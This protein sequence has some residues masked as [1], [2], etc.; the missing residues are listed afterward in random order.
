MN[1]IPAKPGFL[2]VFSPKVA[3]SPLVL[4]VPHAGRIYP[5]SLLAQS[6]LGKDALSALEDRYVDR[7]VMPLA[8]RGFALIVAGAARALIDINRSE[9]EIDPDMVLPRPA[10]AG[11]ELSAKVR[12]GLGIVPRRLA[13]HGNIYPEPLYAADLRQRIADVHRPYHD[14]L[15]DALARARDRFGAAILLDCHSMPPL[16]AKGGAPRPDIVI[17]DRD[18]RSAAPGFAARAL[19]ICQQRDFRTAHNT[20]YPGGH[21]LARH[22]RPERDIHALQLEI[23]RSL[24]LGADGAE[25]GP[26]FAEIGD[27]VIAIAEQ[28]ACEALS[29]PETL[30]AE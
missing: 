20:P 9:R 24:Y 6:R 21:I 26:R 17:G 10:R 13:G 14:A 5:P 12:G 4:S 19:E 23:C 22:G 18:G 11:I 1:D 3:Q 29:G 27:L 8:E 30:A 7:L 28:L 2:R 25:P 15:S 16:R